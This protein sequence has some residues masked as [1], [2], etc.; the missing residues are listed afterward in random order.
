MQDWL[1]PPCIFFQPLCPRLTLSLDVPWQHPVQQFVC[2]GFL[3]DQF[4]SSLGDN[5]LQMVCVLLHHLNHVVHDV[6]FPDRR[7]REICY[8]GDGGGTLVL[9]DPRH[10]PPPPSIRSRS[11]CPSFL[12]PFSWSLVCSLAHSPIPAILMNNNYLI[13]QSVSQWLAHSL[14]LLSLV[15]HPESLQTVGEFASSKRVSLPNC[16]HQRQ[17]IFVS[18]QFLL[19]F[20]TDIFAIFDALHHRWWK[21]RKESSIGGSK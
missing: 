6:D 5:L 17:V 7:L 14:N 15:H 11:Q 12:F 18:N 10:P 20:G 19:N 21:N 8:S 13:I 3:S 9:P 4:W 16:A 2:L 1:R